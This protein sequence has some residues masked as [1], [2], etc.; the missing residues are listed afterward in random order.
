EDNNSV[1]FTE[2][3]SAENQRLAGVERHECSL[4]YVVRAPQCSILSSCSLS[5][6]LPDSYTRYLAK[7]VA[8]PRNEKKPNISVIV[9]M[10]TDEANAGSTL[11]ARSPSGTSVPAVAATN[12][13]MIIAMPRTSPRVGFPRTIQ[14]TPAA[15]VPS[16][17]PLPR[18]TRA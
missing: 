1:G 12:M 2:L 8:R 7:T 14:T 15:T 4:F 3:V 5:L 11:A 9:V 17:T 6:P 10:K 16:T 13:L 18:P